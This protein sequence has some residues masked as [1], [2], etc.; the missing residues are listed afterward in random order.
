MERQDHISTENLKDFPHL[1]MGISINIYKAISI[2]D[3][4]GGRTISTSLKDEQ[5][6]IVRNPFKCIIT[7]IGL[8]PGAGHTEKLDDKDSLLSKEFRYFALVGINRWLELITD[9][10]D[11]GSEGLLYSMKFG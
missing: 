3:N 11:Y 7:Y 10:I 6:V 9:W 4:H 5:I 2:Y 1:R 8:S